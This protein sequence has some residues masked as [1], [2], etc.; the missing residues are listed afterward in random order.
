MSRQ[1][2]SY[3]K[4]T[5]EQRTKTS[6]A[7][8]FQLGC[9]SSIP[10]SLE[11]LDIILTILDDAKPFV[12]TSAGMYERD[13]HG[14]TNSIIYRSRTIQSLE[15]QPPNIIMAALKCFAALLIPALAAALPQAS[16]SDIPPCAY[17]AVLSGLQNTGCDLTD[18]ACVCGKQDIVPSLTSSVVAACDG[19]V[20]D[21]DVTAF[22]SEYCGASGTSAAT[23]SPA[24]TTP[25]STTEPPAST[26][27]MMSTTPTMTSN[28][29]MTNGTN[30]TGSW[31]S[32]TP[33]ATGAP[34]PSE[35]GAP[36][37]SM[38]TLA[39]AVALGGMTWIFAEL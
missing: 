31:T 11:H 25:A 5:A 10:R 32:P 34:I 33:S 18:T 35:G 1:K 29:I 27:D 39:F 13:R 6:T 19:S 15:P 38:S 28:T 9:G 22:I 4:R 20:S 8:A 2:P 21:S 36:I 16:T 7:V 17:S 37:T 24:A 14:F 3:R 26:T 23:T 30:G 12:G